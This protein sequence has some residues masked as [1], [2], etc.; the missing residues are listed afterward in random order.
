[1]WSWISSHGTP[2]GTKP[3]AGDS[4]SS[5]SRSSSTG[6]LLPHRPS[7]AHPTVTGYRRTRSR[8][9]SVKAGQAHRI[10]WAATWDATLAGRV[11]AR[12]PRKLY[13]QINDRRL[14]G[15]NVS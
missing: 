15:E 14:I 5:Y 4:L 6:L 2:A 11:A 8:Q 12:A 13:P 7:L 10:R 9:L 1:M 3:M